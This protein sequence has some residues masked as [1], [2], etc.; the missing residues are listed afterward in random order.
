MRQSFAL[1]GALEERVLAILLLRPDKAY[2]RSALARMLGVPPSSLQRVLARL[3]ESGILQT[4][5]DG[6]RLYYQADT[7]NPVYPELRGLIAKT[8]GLVGVLRDTLGNLR[9]QI[10]IAFV[11][12]SIASGEEAST[13]DVDLFIVGD[14]RRAELAAPLRSA[15]RALGREINPG[16]YTRAE[17]DK[18]LGSGDRFLRAVLDKPKLFV[19]GTEDDLGRTARPKTGRS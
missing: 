6:N 12:G 16:I 19:L 5:R 7:A 17:F 3:A 15:A 2:Y 14:V 10:E 4:R 9:G 11:Y 18:K 8:G 13:S 1:L